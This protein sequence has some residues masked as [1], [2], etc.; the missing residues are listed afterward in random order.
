MD[1][2]VPR[3]WVSRVIP[4]CISGREVHGQ[5]QAEMI[6]FPVVVLAVDAEFPANMLDSSV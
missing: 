5:A 1:Q 6:R 4:N 2:F 3:P